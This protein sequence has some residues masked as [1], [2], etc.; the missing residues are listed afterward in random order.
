MI[1]EDSDH[2]VD[3]LEPLGTETKILS[4]RVVNQVLPAP[5]QGVA[6]RGVSVAEART[7]AHVIDPIITVVSGISQPFSQDCFGWVSSEH[8]WHSKGKRCETQASW[9]LLS[10]PL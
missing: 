7:S 10:N 1:D 9:H 5:W 4:A 8:F 2:F 6:P 3:D